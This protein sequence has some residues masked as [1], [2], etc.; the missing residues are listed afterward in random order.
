MINVC[1]V[2][3]AGR[4][5]DM[6]GDVMHISDL[7]ERG[8]KDGWVVRG[9]HEEG[10]G[11]FANWICEF[12]KYR[13]VFYFSKIRLDLFQVIGGLHQSAFRSYFDTIWMCYVCLMGFTTLDMDLIS[14]SDWMCLV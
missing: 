12:H 2:K 9:C 13:F 11:P 14:R 1:R 6:I 8:A 3:E 10:R 7:K 4:I 5:G